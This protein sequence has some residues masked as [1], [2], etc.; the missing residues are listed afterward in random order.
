MGSYYLIGVEFQCG[1]IK[2]LEMYGDDDQITLRL[3]L[4]ILTYV[5]VRM[6]KMVNF[7]RWVFYHNF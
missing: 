3:Y 5:H 2:L 4:T 7:M 1:K 6:V